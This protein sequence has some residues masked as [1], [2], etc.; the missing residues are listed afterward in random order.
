MMSTLDEVFER[1]ASWTRIDKET[2]VFFY[3]LV[4]LGSI[5][6]GVAQS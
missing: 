5:L 1:L 2:I 3:A 4:L 6:G